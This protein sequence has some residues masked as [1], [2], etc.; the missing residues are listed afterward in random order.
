MNEKINRNDPCPC[1][2][3]KKYKKCC[4]ANQAVSITHLLE[5]EMDDL[6]KQILHY[7]YTHYEL[8]LD[9]SFEEIAEN[10]I[11]PDE[12]LEQFYA[13]IHAVWFLLFE[14]LE[15]G[16]T[17]LEKYIAYE[18]KRIQRPK[19]QQILQSWTNAR[20]IVGEVLQVSE[21]LLTMKVAFTGE[22][23]EVVPLAEEF[24]VTEGSFFMGLMLPYDQKSIFFPGPFELSSITAEAAIQSIETDSLNAGYDEPLEYVEDY[25]IEIMSELPMLGNVELDIENL[26]WPAP[27]Y[28]EVAEIFQKAMERMDE[29]TEAV[30]TGVLLW[31][32]FCQKRQKRMK[33]P[34]NY[35]AALHYLVSTVFPLKVSL[36]QRQLEEYYGVSKGSISPIYGELDY[37]LLH[38]P[39]DA[40][41][42]DPAGIRP[43]SNRS[44]IHASNPMLTERAMREALA[45]LEGGEFKSIEEATRLINEKLNSPKK[46]PMGTKEKAQQMIYDAFESEGPQRYRLAKEALKLD[47]NCVDAYNL[48]AEA[49][50]SLEEAAGIY[51]K[52]LF[53][54]QRELGKKFFQENKGYFWGLMETRPFMRAKF[55]FAQTLVDLGKQQEAIKQYKE[56]LELNPQD[57]QGV[58]YSL[59]IAYIDNDE[60]E[61]ARNLLDEYDEGL[62]RGSYNRALLEIMEHGFTPTASKLMKV[63]KK[64]NKYVIPYLL[65]KK[66]LPSQ[67]PEYYGFG[68][69]NEAIVYADEHLHLWNK[70]NG[71]NDWLKK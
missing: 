32:Q 24:P 13:F 23:V 54:G 57:N 34:N 60:L 18:G 47:P 53:L 45:E 22:Q 61:K 50:P 52:A 33:N 40:E 29:S 44:G 39:L 4:G 67:L 6:Q 28:K 48:L 8:E 46:A 49:A 55:N 30:E 26:D 1:G 62:A 68:D 25:F 7:A 35:A 42:N 20:A 41:E 63:A 2:S 59:F 9:D 64:E 10:I 51:E 70:I 3:G 14:P 38:E 37:V 21:N 36:T 12:Q 66:R 17:I 27:I 19:L 69:E 58:R 16:K 31:H 5:Q 56:L 71:L 43:L 65:G 15:D 11:I